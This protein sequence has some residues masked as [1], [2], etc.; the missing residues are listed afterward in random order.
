VAW[1]DQP[2]YKLLAPQPVAQ[3]RNGV[4]LNRS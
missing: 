4:E 3:G 2:F 1:G